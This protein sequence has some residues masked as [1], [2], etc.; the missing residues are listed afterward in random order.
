METST[1]NVSMNKSSFVTENWPEKLVIGFILIFYAAIVTNFF[2]HY[3]KDTAFS[4]GL[5]L[6]L[7]TW[8]VFILPEQANLSNLMCMSLKYL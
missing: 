7:A 6:I 8:H 3:F 5:L 4:F 1:E 2:R